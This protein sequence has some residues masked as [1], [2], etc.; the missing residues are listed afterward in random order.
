MMTRGRVAFLKRVI[1]S[2]IVSRGAAGFGGEGQ[3][4]GN[5]ICFSEIV[6]VKT[7]A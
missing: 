4:K 7:L 6:S 3:L 2:R 1:A 5:V